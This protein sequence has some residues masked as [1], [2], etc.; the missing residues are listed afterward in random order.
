MRSGRA[1]RLVCLTRDQTVPRDLLL[2]SELV[3]AI[4]ALACARAALH[5]LSGHRRWLLV[6]ACMLFA[7]AA[8]TGFCHY[9]GIG[10]NALIVAHRS[11][12]AAAALAGFGL[13]GAA[14][15]PWRRSGTLAAILVMVAGAIGGLTLRSAVPL[16]LCGGAIV[17]FGYVATWR[18][19][20]RSIP[21][22]LTLFA[23]LI[24]ISAFG[25]VAVAQ[26]DHALALGH[27]A[28]AGW[29]WSHVR[30]VRLSY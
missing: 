27:L 7:S 5:G 24:V 21:A 11:A 20:R 29:L 16:V 2:G 17:V 8:L 26:R 23:A 15:T 3:L 13:A 25:P 30:V 6:A 14:A 12:T 19:A 10:G 4:T 18:N 28:L 1:P 22:A 9:A